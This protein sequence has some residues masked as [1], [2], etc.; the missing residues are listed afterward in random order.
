MHNLEGQPPPD[1]SAPATRAAFLRAVGYGG[2]VSGVLDA[3]DGV[4][5]FGLYGLNP[6]QVL[7]YI[8]SGAFGPAATEGGQLTVHGLLTAAAGTAFHFV[9]A[10]VAA[11]VYA[12][13][14]WCS[15]WLRRNWVAAGLAYGAWVWAFMNLIVLPLTAVV[16]GPTGFGL[17]LN[18]VIGHA[19]FVGL[20]VA[21]FSRRLGHH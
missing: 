15:P 1:S 14:A 12:A 11:A 16:P 21:Y 20:P 3:A 17:T 6:I 19:L 13:A 18:G 5:A 4:V 7:Q 10:F 9:I 8:A 2:L